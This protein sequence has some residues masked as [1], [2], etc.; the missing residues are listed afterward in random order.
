MKKQQELIPM[1]KG[2]YL[3]SLRLE[4]KLSL[5]D[6][7]GVIFLDEKLLGDIEEGNADHIALLYRNGY[8]QTYARFL[9]V[10]ENEI[11]ELLDTA[12]TR[13]PDLHTIFKVP[14]KRNTAEKWL[15]A[16]SYVLASLLVGT[17]A[18]QFTH[19]AVRLSQ[20]GSQLQGSGTIMPQPEEATDVARQQAYGG[21][22]NASIAPLGALH[23][24]TAEGMDAA[25][26]AW[27]A[28]SK[29]ALPDGESL[30]QIFVSA[31]SWVEIADANGQELEMDLLRGGSER[32]YHGK[33]PFRI[34]FGRASAVRLSMDG[35]A[36]DLTA[37]TLDDVAQ[38]SWPQEIQAAVA[39][40]DNN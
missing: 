22:V 21:P 8:I 3:K 5:A 7:A 24:K 35:E 1:V 32:E 4:R 40:P 18:W 25:E 16:S 11:H 15:R 19:E 2:D 26:Q 9:Q 34:L 20:N 39:S 38:L 27:A 33:P 13:E 17:L 37:F 10:P 12:E 36:V 31:D 29:P 6:V 28:M 30:L 23:A 14:P